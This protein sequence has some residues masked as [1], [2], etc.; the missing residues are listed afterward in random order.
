[1][2][3]R[4]TLIAFAVCLSACAGTRGDVEVGPSTALSPRPA[5]PSDIGAQLTT[6]ARVVC[7][8][9]GPGDV[10]TAFGVATPLTTQPMGEANGPACG[11][12]N[13]D[14]RGYLLVIQLQPLARWSSKA[15]SGQAIGSLG[16]PAVQTPDGS[17]VFVRDDAREATVMFLA[18]G[19]RGNSAE[20]LRQ[21]A[22]IV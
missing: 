16:S 19:P 11:Y 2:H 4:S 6:A 8:L 9:V 21:V 1:M 13:V 12:P 15:A 17:Q 10:Q 5:T 14:S 3:G 7:E 18:P 22:A 20:A